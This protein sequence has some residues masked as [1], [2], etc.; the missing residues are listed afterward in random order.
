MKII[1]YKIR[2][3]VSI[4]VMVLGTMLG[5]GLI[6]LV[7]FGN[8]D[9]LG[10]KNKDS[11]LAAVSSTTCTDTDGG[12]NYTQAGY[13]VVSD[14]PNS[15]YTDSCSQEAGIVSLSEF[16]CEDGKSK[17]ETVVCPKGCTNGACTGGLL[18]IS[19]SS[20]PTAQTV[21][22][23]TNE[24]EF[25]RYIF[26]ASDSGDDLKLISMPLAYKYLSGRAT[27]LT[28][29]KLYDGSAALTTGSNVVN[30]A[31]SGQAIN[32]ILDGGGLNILKGF[33][34]EL[35]LK[36]NLYSGA[37]G[38][39]Q[40]GY[41]SMK[42][43]TIVNLISGQ[44]ATVIGRGSSGQ[45]MT[46]TTVGPTLTIGVSTVP[47]AQTVIA[48]TYQFE[49]ARYILDIN[50]SIEDLK[51]AFLPLKYDVSNGGKATDLYSCKLYDGTTAA[52][53]GLNVVNPSTIGS[54]FQ[55]TFDGTGLLIPKGFIKQLSLKCDIK[56][57]ALGIYLW[58]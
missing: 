32:F 31:T 1:N 10:F 18:T 27:D 29:C 22:A 17:A 23:G 42:S 51:I 41:D 56:A 39:Y 35:S 53:T 26:D 8:N 13:V 21:I 12:R 50:N 34:K 11:L 49:F 40:W 25:A 45:L 55:F 4:T 47:T 43:P 16:Y 9:G 19:V 54:S 38:S 36:C 44:P 58:G 24:L 57:A 3:S 20:T 6:G 46:A 48:G 33:I 37:S 5:L 30:P 2:G 7:W 52:T 28:N 14:F 15:Q